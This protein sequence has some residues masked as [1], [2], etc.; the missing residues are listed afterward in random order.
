MQGLGTPVVGRLALED[1]AFKFSVAP[2]SGESSGEH[3]R[4]CCLLM[5]PDSYP[6]GAAMLMLDEGSSNNS[7]SPAQEL[8]SELSERAFSDKAAL[9][10]VLCKVGGLGGSSNSACKAAWVGPT[11]P[12]CLRPSGPA[13]S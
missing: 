5:D 13:A 11:G 1:S 2:S 9:D 8:L 6:S 4:V 3:V 10:T 12:G 7:A